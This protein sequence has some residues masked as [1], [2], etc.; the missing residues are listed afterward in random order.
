VPD[1]NDEYLLYQTLVGAWPLECSGTDGAP[2][3]WTG[4]RARIEGYLEKATRE[5]KVHTSW[6]EPNQAYDAAVR[7]FV[8]RLLDEAADNP[9]LGDLRAFAGRVAAVARWSSLSQVLLKLTA[10]GV[11]DVYQGDELWCVSLV[12]P[13]NRRPVDF[14]RLRAGLA[15]LKR[16]AEE[17]GADLRGLVAELLATSA[18][19]RIKMYVTWRA[20]DFRRRHGDLF[21]TGAYRPL[22]ASGERAEHVCAF[23]R[24]AGEEV[25]LVVAPRLLAGLSGRA[26]RPPT[27]GP[28][29]GGTWLGGPP[30]WAGGRFRNWLTGEVLRA[31]G[32]DGRAALPL[33]EVCATCPVALLEWL[34]PP[35]RAP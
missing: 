15:E 8:G 4:F 7:T 14:A 1:R 18:D 22:E 9:F 21:A 20:L 17:D 23:A 2:A 6:I 35:I 13:D 16:R 30:E 33:A 10:P 32:R 12:D 24:S 19:G 26:E 5:A 25:A 31:T 11:P 3:P 29:W 28:T 27:G 34:P